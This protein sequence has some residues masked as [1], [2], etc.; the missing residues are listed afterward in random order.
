MCQAGRIFDGLL[1]GKPLH[2]SLVG[3]VTYNAILKDARSG[4]WWQQE[5]GQAVKGKMKGRQLQDIP[6]EQMSLKNWLTKHP[7]SLVLQE[8][9]NY[10][11]KYNF[12]SKLIKYEA[13]F[14]RWFNQV[15]PPQVI[16]LELDG[17]SSCLLYTSPSPRDKR[18]SRMPSSA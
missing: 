18:Q 7:D 4:T 3:A 17:N 15:L 11:D 13:S 16:G 6:M 8:D 9:P 10:V 14:P 5:T 2:L 1:D 12:F